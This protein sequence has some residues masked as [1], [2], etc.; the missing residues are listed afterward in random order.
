MVRTGESLLYALASEDCDSRYS[1]LSSSFYTLSCDYNC[2]QDMYFNWPFFLVQAS[3]SDCAC[4][5]RFEL[6]RHGGIQAQ[7]TQEEEKEKEERGTGRRE[8]KEEEKAQGQGSEGVCGRWTFL[9][10]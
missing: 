8:G 4:G 6:G 3:T 1:A 2:N 5:V 10:V 9:L 7:E